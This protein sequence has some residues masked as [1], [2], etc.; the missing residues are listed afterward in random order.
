M[1]AGA[2]ARRQAGQNTPIHSIYIAVPSPFPVLEKFIEICT[3]VYN[4]DLFTSRPPSSEGAVE[5]VQT[6]STKNT[7]EYI[8]DLAPKAVSVG[9]AK[10]GEGMRQALATYKEKFPRISGILI[11]TRRSDPH[12]GECILSA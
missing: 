10:G 9:K 7:L 3:T 4:I 2:L 5:S 8:E 11:G 1:Y 6:P 12:G